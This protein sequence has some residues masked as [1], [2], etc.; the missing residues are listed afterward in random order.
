MCNDRSL[1]SNRLSPAFLLLLILPFYLNDFAS[2]YVDDWR[3]WLTIDY[4]GVKLLPLALV[5]WLVRSGRVSLRDLGLVR[6]GPFAMVAMFL[7]L[8]LVGTIIDQNG[9]RLL[10]G[11]PGYLPLGGM[12]PITN[13]AWDWI[14]LTLGLLLVGI[15]EELVFRGVMLRFLRNYTQSTFAIVII[16]A[17]A[18][19]LIHWSLG[20]TAVLVTTVIG[21]VFMIA[22]IRT[23][24]LVPV[25]L[26]HFAVNFVDFAGLVPKSMFQ[27]V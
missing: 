4:L 25:M 20:L 26:A 11:G 23:G 6:Q 5:A 19:G 13:P 9:Y 8:T 24:S 14:D 16:S 18:F 21:A 7:L 10:E 2:I 17:L 12:P 27:F 22:Y 15:V 1:E 3:V